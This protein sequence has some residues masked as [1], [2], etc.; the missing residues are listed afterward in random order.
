MKFEQ[1]Y[2]S[3]IYFAFTNHVPV[4]A[5]SCVLSVSKSSLPHLFF[6]ASRIFILSNMFVGTYIIIKFRVCAEFKYFRI[7]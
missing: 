3:H 6:P 4:I 7:C 2:I 5:V 1:V